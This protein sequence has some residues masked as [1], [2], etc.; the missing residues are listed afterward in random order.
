[1]RWLDVLGTAGGCFP[2]VCA[3]WDGGAHV[4]KAALATLA[5]AGQQQMTR[6]HHD[7]VT[8]TQLSI[9]TY[10]GCKKETEQNQ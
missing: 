3:V 10:S 6:T 8:D 2:D 7:T 5:V 4:R 9:I 1:M